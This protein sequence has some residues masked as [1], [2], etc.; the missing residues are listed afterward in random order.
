M[1]NA[2]KLSMVISGSIWLIASHQRCARMAR[3]ALNRNVS[4][5]VSFS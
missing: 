5:L 1:T 4:A 3:D 2:K